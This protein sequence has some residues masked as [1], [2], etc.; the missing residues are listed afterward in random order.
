[1]TA[2][3]AG[4]TRSISLLVV[5]DHRI[6]AEVLAM[7]LERELGVTG[8]GLAYGLDEARVLARQEAP[9]VVFLDYHVDGR[10]GT[11]LIADLQ[12]LPN[13]PQVVMLSASEVTQ[14]IIDSLQCGA[15]A[16]VVKGAQVEMLMHATEEVLAGRIYLHPTTVRPVVER[17]LGEAR[18]QREKTFVDDLS[19]RQLEV[20]RCLVAGLDRAEIAQRLY[21]SPNT[22][23]THAQHLLR[24]ADAHSTLALVARAR[25]AGVRG[26]DEPAEPGRGSSR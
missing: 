20:L 3:P 24:V 22:V 11:E 14:E 7:R 13:K 25:E 26:I 1:M 12:A 6:F 8:V 4:L 9:D 19:P 15:S 21:I 17:L 23:R 18:G 2:Q 10:I 5:D 16:W